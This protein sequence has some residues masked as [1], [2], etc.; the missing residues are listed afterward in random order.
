MSEKPRDSRTSILKAAVVEFAKHGL[1][2]TR[3]EHVATRSGFN[4]ALVYRY[5]GSREELFQ[6]AL[7]YKFDQQMSVAVAAPDDLGDALVYWF[8]NASRDLGFVQLLQREALHDHDGEPL[9]HEEFRRHYYV[10]Q[11]ED[12]QARSARGQLDPALPLKP[13]LLVLTALISFPAF[14]PNLTRLICGDDSAFAEDWKRL[15]REL[16]TRL[17]PRGDGRRE[18]VGAV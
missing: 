2:G 8:E 16:A 13:L 18:D 17:G 10:K 4:K 15:L 6:K 9:A 7:E 12:L 5:F 1:S 11:L 3:M 14:F